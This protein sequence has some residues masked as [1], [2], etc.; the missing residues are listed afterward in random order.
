MKKNPGRQRK[1][2]RASSAESETLSS[3]IVRIR[4]INALNSGNYVARTVSGIAREAHIKEPVVVHAIKSDPELRH[5]V[6]VYPRRTDD[7]RLLFTT[8]KRFEEN[9]PIKDKFVDFFSTNRLKLD[10]VS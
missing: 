7:G 4:I 3:G 6:K 5:M 9:A 2:G 10:D 1:G 8:K